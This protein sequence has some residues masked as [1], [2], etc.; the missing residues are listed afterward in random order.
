MSE[1]VQVSARKQPWIL[2]TI[3]ITT[4]GA[5]LLM[6]A[7]NTLLSPICNDLGI[8]T[9][10]G[11]WLVSGEL[12]AVGIVMPLSAFLIRRFPTRNLYLTGIVIFICGL[13]L[14]MFSPSFGIMMVGRVLQGCGNGLL[15]SMA[16]VIIL[17]TYPPEKRGS[18]MGM[19]GLAVA[20]A[21]V[22]APTLAGVFADTLGWRFIF[23]VVLIAMI[24]A[25][26]MA[27]A[28]LANVLETSK[29]KVDILSFILSVLAFGGITLGIGNVSN[30]GI[31]SPLVY[32][33]LI[34]G[35]IAM[36]LFVTRQV[37]SSAPFLNLRIIRVPAY[38]IA[39]VCSMLLYFVHMGF[40]LL[41]PLYVQKVMLYPATI[42]G[43]V[44]L[45]GSIAMAIVSPFA[46]R[47]YDKLGIKKLAI[48]GTCLMLCSN[49]CMACLTDHSSLVLPALFNI[50]RAV[51]VASLNM[52]L[53]TYAVSRV[54][55]NSVADATAV[56]SSFRTIMGSIGSAVFSGIMTAVAAS[57][58]AA[59]GDLASLHG[60]KVAFMIMA[61]VSVVLVLLAIFP[62]DRLK[63]ASD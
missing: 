21:P 45:P 24:I 15:L 49:I 8:E 59:Y 55:K 40:S 30:Y 19:Y 7:M 37:K 12:L 1:T 42:S 52:T 32:V 48:L 5:S 61:C 33:S 51:S 57:S 54:D 9:S 62:L 31:T 38:T 3:M 50:F 47:F 35:V 14:S 17:S 43:L 56:T 6:T 18:A 58:A 29:K 53:M 4:V 23:G 46:G 25:L 22:I 28:V 13:L 63:S 34:V 60:L 44:T 41:T 27:I 36:V 39:L 16:Q 20:L 2:A 11:R 10:L 26:I